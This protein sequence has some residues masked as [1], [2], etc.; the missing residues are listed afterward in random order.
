MTMPVLATVTTTTTRR[1]LLVDDDEVDR[2]AARRALREAGLDV[3]VVEV[4]DGAAAL[5]RLRLGGIDCVL[6]DY[7]L[8]GL[9]G[10]EL[11]REIQRTPGSPP[12]IALTGTGD[13]NV[14]VELMQAGAVDY[15]P[16]STLGAERLGR[17]VRYAWALRSA[18]EMAR[19]A[20]RA[21][22]A[23]LM[24]L[25]ALV[26]AAPAIH[27][28]RAAG[29][30]AAVTAS[31]AFQLFGAPRVDVVIWDGGPP[32]HASEAAPDAADVDWLAAA[33]A[34]RERGMRGLYADG[35]ALGAP[36]HGQD[37]AIL[38]W[39]SSNHASTAADETLLDQL[40]YNVAVAI[41]SARLLRRAEQA[42]RTRDDIMAIVSHDLRNP[43]AAIRAAADLLEELPPGAPDAPSVLASIQRS[44]SH[45]QR[46]IERQLAAATIEAGSFRVA[47]KPHRLAGLIDEAVAIARPLAEQAGVKLEPD[48]GPGPGYDDEIPLDRDR[49][50]EVL[51]NLLG[52]ALKFTP[53]G[54]KVRLGVAGTGDG[55]VLTVRD[56]GPGIEPGQLGQVFERYWKT[57]VPGGRRGIGLG[58]YI[59]RGIVAA[60][61]GRI[62]VDSAP[63]QGAAFHVLLPRTSAV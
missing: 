11:L 8:P 15:I 36:L 63:G 40:A 10:L 48:G 27:A 57:D 37:G 14:A 49:I 39:L 62:W 35:L 59:A 53:S 45:M 20:E 29:E 58:L 41:D 54:G 51:S 43:L 1:V 34:V 23:Y 17:S 25:R 19:R 18:E 60:H 47:P 13:E 33:L 28:A 46:L 2:M 12:M 56:D 30:L 5:E 61:G 24:K 22:Q 21:R 50:L 52:N 4:G 9:D 26:E 31:R 7:Q 6:A 3:E 38:V 55:V 16:K 44:V 42:S 32:E